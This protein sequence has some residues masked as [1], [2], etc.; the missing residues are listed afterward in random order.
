VI[1][2]VQFQR[3]A[4]VAANPGHSVRPISLI[5]IVHLGSQSNKTGFLPPRILDLINIVFGLLNMLP[6]LPFDGGHVAIAGYEWIRTKKGEAY[7]KADIT[8]LF[9]VVFVVMAFLAIFVCRAV[10]RYHAPD[11]ESLQ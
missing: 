7:Y 9:P 8:K 1:T 6:M 5:G 10:S 3:R 2:G 11:Q 4:Q